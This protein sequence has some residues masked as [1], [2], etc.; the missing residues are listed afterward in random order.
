MNQKL[1]R[2]AFARLISARAIMLAMGAPPLIKLSK[3]EL[4]KLKYNPIKIALLEYEKGV[5]PL[6]VR[7]K[8]K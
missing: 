2:F 7:F 5:L 6:I 8:G 4:E 3:E 1:S